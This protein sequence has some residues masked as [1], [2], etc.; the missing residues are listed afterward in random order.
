[1][2]SVLAIYLYLTSNSILLSVKY[3]HRHH[4]NFKARFPLLRAG[5]VDKFSSQS[6]S[7][8]RMVLNVSRIHSS[9]SFYVFLDLSGLFCAHAISFAHFSNPAYSALYVSKP[10][11]PPSAEHHIQV[12][13]ARRL[14]KLH[15]L[16]CHYA[17]ESSV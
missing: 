5:L 14:N 11:H 6:S 15:P 9:T 10:H 2:V 13:D 3:V 4:I 12:P 1:M 17:E 8:L 7:P 16:H